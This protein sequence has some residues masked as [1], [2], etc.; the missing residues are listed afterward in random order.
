MMELP[1]LMPKGAYTKKWGM[2][3]LV[4]ALL[5]V[6]I[7]IFYTLFISSENYAGY[8]KKGK[9]NANNGEHLYAL[10][11]FQK[12]LEYNPDGVEAMTGLGWTYIRL[13][14]YSTAESL[15]T[16]AVFKHPFDLDPYMAYSE[17]KRL[18]GDFASAIEMLKKACDAIPD[19][20][21][22]YVELGKMYI[23]T[24]QSTMA[25]GVLEKALTLSP[26]D[27]EALSKL[28]VAKRASEREET[29][30]KQS[31]Q[32]FYN[33]QTESISTGIADDVDI[34]PII[35]DDGE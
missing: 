3:F 14:A 31:E 6:V 19:S 27:P 17:S 21:H 11:A 28:S 13:Q 2:I 12:A 26:N 34:E 30:A 5:F 33:Y 35:I 16:V 1:D 22:P 9:S 24:G 25:V 29:M 10:Q 32:K 7:W 23:A 20:A 15:L 8:V 18:Q 4:P